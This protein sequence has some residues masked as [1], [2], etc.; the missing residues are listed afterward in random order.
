VSICLSPIRI[1]LLVVGTALAIATPRAEDDDHPAAKKAETPK[2]GSKQDGLTLDAAAQARI[3]L[4]VS[5]LLPARNPA[6]AVAHGNVLDPSPLALLDAE[7]DGAAAA[8]AIARGQEK[9]ERELFERDQIVARPA[10]EAAQL[11]VQMA[12]TRHETALRRLA[13]E[14]GDGFAKTAPAG[15]RALVGRLLRREVILL[16]VELP[17]G[18]TLSGTPSDAVVTTLASEHGRAARWFCDAPTVDART[19]GRGFLFQAA[20]PDP[21]MRPGTAI[22]ARITRDGPAEPAMLVPATA[23]IRHLGLAWIYLAENGGRF[24]K[25][26]VTLDRLTAEGWVTVTSLPANAS[27]VTRGAQLL[28]SEE[29]KARSAAE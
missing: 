5:K 12:E 19:Q 17:A 9:R 2:H 20:G 4:E 29:L 3:G 25:Q 23:V 28:L 1:A 27:V 7:L 16:R 24:R 8:L 15:R 6:V 11:Q 26:A 18:E 14:W 13:T 21:D 22:T 10:L